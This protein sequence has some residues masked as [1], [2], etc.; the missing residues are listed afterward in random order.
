MVRDD[1]GFYRAQ[2]ID[3]VVF[4]LAATILQIVDSVMKSPDSSVITREVMTDLCVIKGLGYIKL[5]CIVA[6]IIAIAGVLVYNIANDSD[7]DEE[8]KRIG[9]IVSVITI[10]VFIAIASS[11]IPLVFGTPSVESVTV[12]QVIDIPHA[13]GRTAHK[14]SNY[15]LFLSDGRT[16]MGESL[17]NK[18]VKE[19]EEFYLIICNDKIQ[20]IYSTQDHSV[21]S[22]AGMTV[23]EPEPTETTI[24]TLPDGRVVVPLDPDEY[25]EEAVISSWEAEAATATNES[26]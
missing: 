21:A 17:D 22:D 14:E 13:S 26:E 3:I 20:F 1:N 16:L 12:V 15:K 9:R 6:L 18:H 5:G 11:G 8:F 10:P 23:Y 4:F 25:S 7:Y 19:G 2:I 24:Q